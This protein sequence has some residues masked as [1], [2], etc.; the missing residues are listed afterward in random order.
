MQPRFRRHLRFPR[1]A[2]VIAA[3]LAGFCARSAIAA[4]AVAAVPGMP[5]VINPDNLYSEAQ[6][7]RMSVAVSGALSRI[8]VPNLRSNDVYV[9]DPATYKVVDRFAVGRSPQHVVPAWDLQTLWVANNAEG[10]TDGSLTPIDPKTGK[11]G[12]EVSVDDP[13]NMYFTPDGKEAIV[14]AEAH[15]R[16]DFRDPKT[17]ALK[18]S[19]DVPQCKGINHADFSIDG[20]YALFTCEFGGKLAKIDL[21]NRK[22]IGYLELDRKGMPQDIRV[23]PDGKVFYVADMMADGVYVV[24]GDRFAKIGFIPTGVGTH[25]LYPS[26]DGT[27]LYIANRGS[28]LVHGPRHGKGSVSVLDFATRKVVATWPIPGGGSPD[29]G[30]VSADG[31]TLWLSGRFDDVVYA[32]DTASGAVRSIPVGMEPHGLTVWP[33]PGRYSLGH[34]GNMR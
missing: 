33:Q 15:A 9:I 14:V 30:N 34:T 19:L 31:K 17:M 32:I 21:V 4:S 18:S 2:I 13:Y 25:G 5:P 26:R 20:R 1:L 10:R 29:M 11:P 3:A 8:Y 7:G 22:V 16:L 12:Q 24:D 27:R 28:N 23:S 6:A